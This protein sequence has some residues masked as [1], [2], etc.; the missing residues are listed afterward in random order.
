MASCTVVLLVA[1]GQGS[2]DKGIRIPPPIDSSVLVA[3]HA[4]TEKFIDTAADE[5]LMQAVIDDMSKRL[6]NSSTEYATIMTWN[7]ARRS[8]FVAWQLDAEVSNG[9][10]SQFFYNPSGK[11][12]PLVP[13][14]LKYVGASLLADLT[15]RANKTYEQQL[16]NSKSSKGDSLNEYDKAYHQLTKKESL[17]KMLV[18][19]VRAHKSAFVEW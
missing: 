6:G 1:C 14:S 2:S 16:E 8:V 19:F 4:L 7:K 17:E 11:F 15:R 13:E 9:G 12:Y 18:D 5:V 3:R 10:F